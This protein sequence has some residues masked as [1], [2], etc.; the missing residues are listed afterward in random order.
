M[1]DEDAKFLIAV[2]ESKRQQELAIKKQTDAALHEFRV[3]HEL[4]SRE[5]QVQDPNSTKI[6]PIHTTL[7]KINDKVKSAA[8]NAPSELAIKSKRN[9]LGIAPKTKKIKK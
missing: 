1:T 7:A 4:F 9:L 8:Q 5:S 3:R 2:E 6:E